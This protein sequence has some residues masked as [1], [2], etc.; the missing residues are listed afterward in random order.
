MP[1][2]VTKQRHTEQQVWVSK[3]LPRKQQYKRG[4]EAGSRI[5]K[6]HEVLSQSIQK[7]PPLPKPDPEI[8]VVAKLVMQIPGGH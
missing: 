4:G 6:Q 2:R 7:R 3:G 5:L 8:R 1:M